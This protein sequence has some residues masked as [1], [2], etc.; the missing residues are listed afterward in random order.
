MFEFDDVE[1]NGP[2]PLLLSRTLVPG[3][4]FSVVEAD[5]GATSASTKAARKAD[6]TG[7]RTRIS[8]PPAVFRADLH[9]LTGHGVPD[10]SAVFTFPRTP[11]AETI[12]TARSERGRKRIDE[13]AE[14]CASA[15]RAARM[16]APRHPA[17]PSIALAHRRWPPR[18][19]RNDHQPRRH[20]H[21]Q[22]ALR[23]LCGPRS[24]I[25]RLTG[26]RVAPACLR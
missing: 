3:T 22:A 6:P 1:L 14:H 11:A 23:R 7:N 25:H 4:V 17:G 5:A 13:L 16:R 26:P 9:G 15:L 19:R 20:H 8:H 18:D 10:R 24:G 21:P 12:S 2:L